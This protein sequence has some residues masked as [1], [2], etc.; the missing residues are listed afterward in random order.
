[1]SRVSNVKFVHRDARPC[2]DVARI[3]LLAREVGLRLIVSRTSILFGAAFGAFCVFKIDQ[4]GSSCLEKDISYH[5]KA[6]VGNGL[7]VSVCCKVLKHLLVCLVAEVLLLNLRKFTQVILQLVGLKLSQVVLTQNHMLN[8]LSDFLIE[9][10]HI[11]LLVNEILNLLP[12]LEK[13][14]VVTF[15]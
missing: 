5:C 6:D 12:L 14:I 7:E 10:D 8:K 1:M 4:L 13:Q 2:V 3:A 15:L 11:W 9:L